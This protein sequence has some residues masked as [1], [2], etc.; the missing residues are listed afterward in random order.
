[1]YYITNNKDDAK[2]LAQAIY[3]ET[4]REAEIINDCNACRVSCNSISSDFIYNLALTLD[5]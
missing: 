1:M 3:D 5:V 4:G 2:L